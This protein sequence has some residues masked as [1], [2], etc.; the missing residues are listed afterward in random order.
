M[1][2]QE[3]FRE[4]LQCWTFM[5]SQFLQYFQLLIMDAQAKVPEDH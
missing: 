4:F 1:I 5:I 2:L 3:F